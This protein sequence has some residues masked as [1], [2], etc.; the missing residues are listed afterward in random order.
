MELFLVILSFSVLAFVFISLI[1][2]GVFHRKKARPKIYIFEP[3][4][5][6]WVSIQKTTIIEVE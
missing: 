1:T 6:K 3:D 2:S 4:I 5:T